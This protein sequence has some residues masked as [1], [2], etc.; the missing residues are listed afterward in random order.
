MTPDQQVT[1][2]AL[3]RASDFVLV[4]PA[5][6]VVLALRAVL[7]LVLSAYEVF[8]L[9]A[10]IFAL[11]FGVCTPG[12]WRL[13]AAA[14]IVFAIAGVKDMLP[15]ADIAEAHNAFLVINEGEPL[16]HGLPPEIFR[17]WKAQFDA[18]Y[19]PAKQPSESGYWRHA[20]VPPA[21][22]TQSADAI[23]RPAN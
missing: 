20:G 14:A 4:L 22:F 12:W 1:D 13:G 15:R 6:Y 9:L 16:Q 17:S 10:A 8:V 7:P 5:I 18:L 19:P 3:M 11:V 2:E 23:W 21:L